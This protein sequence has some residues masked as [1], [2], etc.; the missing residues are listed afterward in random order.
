M[1]SA[2]PVR[3]RGTM[4]WFNAA[5]DCGALQTEEGERIDVPGEAFLPGEKP[6]GRCAGRPV[7]FESLEG[8]AGRIAFVSELSQRRA[9]L[10]HRR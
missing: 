6:A 10:R 1:D 7:E 4:L 5:K 8:S 9:R 3:A 2:T